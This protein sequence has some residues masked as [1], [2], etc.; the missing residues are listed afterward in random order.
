M[1][2]PPEEQPRKPDDN[3]ADRKASYIKF[4]ILI[5]FFFLYYLYVSQKIGFQHGFH[6]LVLTW[7]FLVLCT[8]VSDAGFIVDFPVVLLFDIPMFITQIFVFF[9]SI[10]LVIFYMKYG[11]LVAT[12][13]QTEILRQFYRVLTT[14]NP[15][16]W[17][18]VVSQIGTFTSVRLY[19][20]IYFYIKDRVTRTPTEAP[21][22]K[23]EFMILVTIFALTWVVWGVIT[24][25]LFSSSAVL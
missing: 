4:G 16:Y 11:A 5:V 24:K 8:P 15:W 6:V 23:P 2:R 18:I 17:Y 14:P 10:F 13:T 19:D 25:A 1:A 22:L 7:C 9:F 21:F 12:Y 20:H 3:G